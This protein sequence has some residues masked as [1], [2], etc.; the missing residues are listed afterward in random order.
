MAVAGEYLGGGE[1]VSGAERRV[2]GVD[3]VDGGCLFLRLTFW[4]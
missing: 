4:T 1:G 3:V 2:E